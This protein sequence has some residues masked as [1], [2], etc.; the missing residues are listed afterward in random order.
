MAGVRVQLASLT[1]HAITAPAHLP[2]EHCGLLDSVLAFGQIDTG[3]SDTA[4]A[5]IASATCA[6]RPVHTL[7]NASSMALDSPPPLRSQRSQ[8]FESFRGRLGLGT[9]SSTSQEGLG[10]GAPQH[11][12]RSPALDRPSTS[13]TAVSVQILSQYLITCVRACLPVQAIAASQQYRSIHMTERSDLGKLH[14]NLC[15]W[16]PGACSAGGAGAAAASAR[17]FRV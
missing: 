8:L 2:L 4:L 9:G 12:P 7:Q 5:A 17:T 3:A 6:P 1:I 11:Q 13:P 15:T 10:S 14:R 16:L